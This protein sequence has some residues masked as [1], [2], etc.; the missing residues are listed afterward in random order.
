MYVDSCL[1]WEG[2]VLLSNSLIPQIREILDFRARSADASLEHTDRGDAAARSPDRC[3]GLSPRPERYSNSP[4]ALAEGKFQRR[5]RSNSAV[6]LC[7]V[8]ALAFC[9]S[10][11]GKANE[12][13]VSTLRVWTPRGAKEAWNSSSWSSRPPKP[14]H[15]SQRCKAQSVALLREVHCSDDN[16]LKTWVSAL[17]NPTRPRRRRRRPR[18]PAAAA[19]N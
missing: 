4:E 6:A 5:W 17:P 10:I 19:P 13:D 15:L 1:F 11:G 3:P 9:D 8:W 12:L 16:D 14:V 7:V 2:T 18:R